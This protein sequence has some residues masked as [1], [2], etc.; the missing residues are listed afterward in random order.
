MHAHIVQGIYQESIL[1]HSQ[2][3]P[4]CQPLMKFGE[5][6][7]LAFQRNANGPVCKKFEVDFVT[8]VHT[9]RLRNRDFILNLIL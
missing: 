7:F 1:T 4:S 3:N 8:T 9:D 2:R 6:T 5:E